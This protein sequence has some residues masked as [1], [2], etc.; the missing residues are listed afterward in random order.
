MNWKELKSSYCQDV[1]KGISMGSWSVFL[2]LILLVS[3][4][5]SPAL[6]HKVYVFAWAEQGV[7]YT[8]SSFGDRKVNKGSIEVEDMTGTL[9]TD[10]VTDDQ[11]N[12]SFKI[13]KDVNSNLV[14]KLDASMGHQAVWTVSLKE[15]QQAMG[16]A[17]SSG[18]SPGDLKVSHDLHDLAM[19]QKEELEKGPS[20]VRI[21]AGIGIIFILAFAGAWVRGRINRRRINQERLDQDQ[22]GT[23]NTGREQGD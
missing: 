9:V 11:G 5:C 19:A 13:P 1:R 20:V 7:V 23:R 6:A 3:G 21:I 18:V 22:A 8:E 14:V 12:F 15:M 2:V 10:G 4:W 17:D 16:Q